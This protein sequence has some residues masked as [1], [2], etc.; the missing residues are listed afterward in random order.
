MI[1]QATSDRTTP[2]KE[3]L[4]RLGIKE[5]RL[6]RLQQVHAGKV[7]K[8]TGRTDLS[9]EIPGA[10]AAVTDVKGLALS[11]RTADCLPVFFHDPEHGA[12]GIA[13]AGWRSTKER[14]S[15]SVVLMMASEYGSDPA[16]LVVGFGPALRQCCYE[17]KSE[18]LVHFPDSVV[19]MAHKHFFDIAGENAEQMLSAGVVSKNIYDCGICTS[20]RNAEYFS[21]RKEKDAAGRM[22][23]VIM[24]V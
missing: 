21:Y 10:D 4:K 9:A 11:V 17:V 15:P 24:L 18:F 5:G 22:L 3:F 7:V 14:I 19:K 8:V 16:K 6:A 23:S 2:H 1:T 20:C 13:H 12:I